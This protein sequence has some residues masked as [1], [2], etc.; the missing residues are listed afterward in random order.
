MTGRKQY[1]VRAVVPVSDYRLLLTFEDGDRR[2]FDVKPY[3]DKGVFAALRAPDLFNSV[4]VSFDSIQW[5]NGA[6]LCPEVLFAESVR[7]DGGT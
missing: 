1:G 2:V 6:D 5:K 7:V 3:L 4:R